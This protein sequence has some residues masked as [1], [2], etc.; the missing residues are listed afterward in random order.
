MT[1]DQPDAEPNWDLLPDDPEGF[2]G[3]GEGYGRKDLKRKYGALVRRFKPERSPEKFKRIRAA[4]EEIDGWLR[5]GA[6]EERSPA[7]AGAW[8]PLRDEPGPSSP[9]AGI[10]SVADT[11]KGLA[12][13]PP[14]D[15]AGAY[16]ELA[17][18]GTKSPEHYVTLA[19]LADLVA[20]DQRGFHNWLLEGIQAH[21]GSTALDD[22]FREY[23]RAGV[24]DS[25]VR[26]VIRSA[27]SVLSAG[28]FFP[29]TEPLWDR[30]LNLCEFGEFKATLAE[31][32][33]HLRERSIFVTAVFSLHILKAAFFKAD[34]AWLDERLAFLEKHHEEIPHFMEADHLFLDLLRA[35][36]RRRGSFVNGTPLQREIDQVIRTYCEEGPRES[37]KRFMQLQ[38]RIAGDEGE[39]LS[40]FD[41][42]RKSWGFLLGPYTWVAGDLEDRLGEPRQSLR[43]GRLVNMV[44]ELARKIE[45][46]TDR[47]SLGVL[48]NFTLMAIPISIYA[49]AT[50]GPY[51]LLKLAIGAE[52]PFWYSYD[53]FLF[54][55]SVIG[56]LFISK[57]IMRRYVGRIG[58]P[59]VSGWFAR[60]FYRKRWRRDAL[61]F[62]R[63]TRIA[64]DELA[65]LMSSIRDKEIATADWVAL[66]VSADPALAL[67]SIAQR[68]TD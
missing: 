48:W 46:R 50:F 61:A 31:C 65:S 3:L 37:D 34:R 6:R 49:I 53:L 64:A 11:L 28:R 68:F 18:S 15:L 33:S 56:G 40:T 23:C 8:R 54:F 17:A 66:F 20:S 30:L 45:R 29:A 39:L 21:P 32:E 36:R 25:L 2:F 38:L 67:F 14:E 24:P 27:A 12:G 10:V 41:N 7:G 22:L 52:S 57:W 5:Y 43:R 42:T 55:G 47:A 60:R 58:V 13:R 4:Y 9:S 51:A 44:Q 16:D 26:G 62:M 1:P 19:F 59:R 35:Y 63:R